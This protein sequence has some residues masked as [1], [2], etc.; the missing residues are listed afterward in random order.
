MTDDQRIAWWPELGAVVAEFRHGLSDEA[1]RGWDAVLGD[2]N[3]NNPFATVVEWITR[4]TGRYIQPWMN[5][6]HQPQ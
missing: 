1:K 3:R 5:R 4:L 6:S 2:L